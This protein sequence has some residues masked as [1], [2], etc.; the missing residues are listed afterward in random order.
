MAT[1]KN[2]AALGLEIG[3]GTL[4]PGRRADLLVLSADPLAHL[5][6]LR[7]IQD[8]YLAGVAQRRDVAS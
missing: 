7:T 1:A 3:H 5:D 4:A 2:A 8:V 6:N